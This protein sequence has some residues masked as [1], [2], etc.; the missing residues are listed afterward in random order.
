[1]QPLLRDYRTHDVIREDQIEL[2]NVGH[3]VLQCAPSAFRHPAQNETMMGFC[4]LRALP[5]VVFRERPRES[6]KVVPIRIS[7]LREPF[8]NIARTSGLR[9]FSCQSLL[10]IEAFLTRT[11]LFGYRLSI[12]AY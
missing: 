5:P 11:S 4:T 12:S 8:L 6:I 2:S 7:T 3:D 10:K 9:R 1:M